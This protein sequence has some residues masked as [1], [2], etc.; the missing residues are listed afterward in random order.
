M[1]RFEIKILIL[2]I[3]NFDGREREKRQHNRC[4]LGGGCGARRRSA[5]EA[6]AVADLAGLGLR[7]VKLIQM[8]NKRQYIWR[9]DNPAF[10]GDAQFAFSLDWHPRTFLS[11]ASFV[12]LVFIQAAFTKILFSGKKR[13]YGAA[14][15]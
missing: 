10:V 5:L 2:E 11:P 12:L 14:H 13:R 7:R 1:S 4:G 6:L 9:N 3:R 15:Q 8:E